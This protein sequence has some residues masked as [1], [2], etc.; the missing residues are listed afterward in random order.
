MTSRNRKEELNL[1]L[2]IDF[3]EISDATY[4]SK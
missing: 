1:M 4:L 3:I 2:F